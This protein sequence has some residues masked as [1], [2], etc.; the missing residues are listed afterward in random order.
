[1]M[2]VVMVEVAS[3]IIGTLHVE[4]VLVPFANQHLSLPS[5]VLPVF[6]E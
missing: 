3:T 6:V 4:V 1:M 2:L 5:L